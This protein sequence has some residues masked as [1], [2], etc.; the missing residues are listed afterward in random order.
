MQLLS[1][2]RMMPNDTGIRWAGLSTQAIM[3]TKK[4]CAC[5]SRRVIMHTQSM[6]ARVPDQAIVDKA[7]VVA[8]AVLASALHLLGG[9]AEVV[10]RWS[11][12]IQEAV[13]SKHAMVQFHAVAL[14]HALRAADRLAVSKLVTSLTR[15]AVRSPLAQC[16]LVRCAAARRRSLPSPPC[17]LE[18][19]V[20]RRPNCPPLWPLIAILSVS[21][22][23]PLLLLLWNTFMRHWSRG[24]PSSAGGNCAAFLCQCCCV[25][26]EGCGGRRARVLAGGACA[27][28][29][30][31]A[32]V[33]AESTAA[34]AGA[35]PFYD[36]LESCL[37]HKVRPFFCRSSPGKPACRAHARQ[38][39][40][41][42]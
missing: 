21:N 14:L 32:Q 22:T 23:T 11:N 33:I 19:L 12:E 4:S 29:R 26:T 34:G 24:T 39:H 37:R 40:M 36:F 15:G 17:P 5:P 41:A 38:R 27:R 6:H 30:Y 25:S 8:S 16:L 13:Q 18:A 28:C 42:C 31:V 35:R 10:K 3:F 1:E 7:A 9:N 20:Y 2:S